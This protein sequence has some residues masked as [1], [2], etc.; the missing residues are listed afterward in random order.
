MDRTPHRSE[1]F[2]REL[3]ELS[4]RLGRPMEQW[5]RIS[6]PE[7]PR[8]PAGFPLSSPR[9]AEVVLIVPRP[10]ERVL[11][12]TKNFYPTGVW[13]LPTGGL[14]RRES[15]EKAVCRESMEET[16]HALQPRR[17][18]F[19]IH[20]RWERSDNDFQSFGFLMS[21][22]H[23]KIRSR[24]RR[25]QISAFRDSDRRAIRGIAQRLE[26]LRGTW[27]AWGRFRAVPHRTLLAA[28]PAGGFGV[29]GPNEEDR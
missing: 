16:G 24:D 25:E 13:R 21:Q 6:T 8:G 22:A 19:H 5:V 29:S 14:H 11:V 1:I 28:W 12:H 7:S 23:G 3:A 20:F 10:R 2:Q 9:T 27:I 4:R 18:L 15:I 17:F 26:T